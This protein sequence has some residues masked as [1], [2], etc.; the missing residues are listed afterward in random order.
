M[1]GSESSRSSPSRL[2]WRH[3]TSPGM[4]HLVPVKGFS[5]KE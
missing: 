5:L 1:G 4:I 2:W 3:A